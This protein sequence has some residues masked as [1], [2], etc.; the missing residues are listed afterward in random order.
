ME[1]CFTRFGVSMRR[2]FFLILI[3]LLF[4]VL[5]NFGTSFYLIFTG[6]NGNVVSTIHYRDT[7]E[8]Q[9]ELNKYN[10]DNIDANELISRVQ[11][12]LAIRVSVLKELRQFE[13]NRSYVIKQINERNDELKTI[14]AQIIRKSN[15]LDRVQLHI[16]QAEL[17]RKEA[18]EWV[19]SLIE[20]PLN[21][22]PK[23]AQ[24]SP[25]IQHSNDV[26]IDRTSNRHC[27]MYNCFDYSRCSLFSTFYVFIYNIEGHNNNN[28]HLVQ[29]ETIDE[30]LS[31]HFN[32]NVHVTKNPKIAC[33][34]MVIIDDHFPYLND[35]NR[36]K[37]YLYSLPYWGGDG[38]NHVIVNLNKLNL[39][40]VGIEPMKAMLFQTNFIVFDFRV[41]YDL[42]IPNV[43]QIYYLSKNLDQFAP[44][45]SPARRKYFISYLGTIHSSTVQNDQRVTIKQNLLNLVSKHTKAAHNEFL[46]DFDC[47][48]K[49]KRLCENQTLILLDST[50]TLILPSAWPKDQ[51]IDSSYGLNNSIFDDQI[52]ERFLN[53]LSTGSIPVLIGGDYVRLPFEEIIDWNRAMI[54]IPI[55]RTTEFY[56][57]LKTFT[58]SDIIEMRRFGSFI[59]RNYFSNVENFV[60]TLFA[61]L[62]SVRLKI[63]AP[64]IINE[65]SSFYY[66]RKELN[67]NESSISYARVSS[68][69]EIVGPLEPPISS[70]NFNRN[71]TISFT[72]QY[73]SWNEEFH[74]P[75]YTYPSLPVDPVLPSE[76]KFIGSSYGFRPI[77][78]GAGGSGREYSE[79]LGGNYIHEQFTIVILTY[80][81]EGILLSALQRLKDLPYLN[82]VIVVWNSPHP[83]NESIKWPDIGVE[84]V[85]IK[86]KRNS[87]NNRFLPFDEIKTD[88]ILSLD[89]DVSFRHDEIVFAFK[90]WRQARDVIVGF[91]ARY[92]AWD[93]ANSNWLYNSN[94][95]CEFS[96][97]L[98]GAAFFHK[99]YAYMYTYSMPVAIRDKVDEFVNCED[100]AMNFLVSHIS[101]K[102]PIKVT[103]RW[104]FRCQDCLSS[105]SEDDL[106]Y[107]RRHK[108]LNYFASVYGYMPLL[109]TQFRADSVLF[110][111]RIPHDK[112]KCFKYI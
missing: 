19:D 20:P 25:S 68:Y 67:Q 96:M 34:Y 50:F 40:H 45:L 69:D 78:A 82:K 29:Q 39:R 37:H 105:L 24:E 75:L 66:N 13:R 28:N 10:L 103:S 54:R 108:C 64:P 73:E 80:E 63:P 18:R 72:K 36:F 106:H 59:F 12:L 104:T 31:K 49:T 9:D 84:I 90:T 55:S 32:G 8:V 107:Q 95:T 15:E 86:S 35:H 99:Y 42:I 14:K 56:V 33:I 61:F 44:R 85:V 71:Y 111:T 3:A 6:F 112:Q 22:L 74:S 65:Q 79:A 76:S 48:E 41:T 100:I 97:I 46:L 52:S 77:G 51:L 11:E 17:A 81:R 87:L 110:K 92:H 93:S 7:P 57:V 62:R 4:V 27:Q 53:A 21:I 98:T 2:L 47:D 1:S 58:D 70:L 101:R 83:P 109:L 5:L 94:Y 38:R 89:D 43:N 30:I 60:N 23:H 91:P 26:S 102:P 88:A 16:K